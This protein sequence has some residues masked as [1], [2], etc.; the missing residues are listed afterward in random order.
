[1]SEQSESKRHYAFSLVELLVCI[2]IISLLIAL[3]LP[4]VKSAR[5]QALSVTCKAHLH[6]NYQCMLMYANN[7]QGW[8][9]P[10]GL[11]D[12]P[13]M[14]REK[15]WPSLVFDPPVWNPPT[16]ICPTDVEPAEEHSY[17]LNDHVLRRQIR[18]G[19]TGQLGISASDVILMGEKKTT[20]GDY[21]M[22]IEHG[23]DDSDFW[24]K[25]EKYRHG[26]QLG[27]N[28]LMLDG[29][30]TSKMPAEVEGA[31]DPWDVAPASQ[32]APGP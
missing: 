18:F 30:V 26:L 14:P 21:Y 28:Y 1:M 7:N 5:R 2:A 17:V 29:S 23:G 6:V 8:W 32:P 20:V 13:G 19:K 31:I 16:M 15:R 3:L 12:E 27:S 24:T 10:R 25:V 9:A 22:E 4:A 11:G